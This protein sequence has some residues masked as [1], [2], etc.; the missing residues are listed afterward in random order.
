MYLPQTTSDRINKLLATTN[1]VKADLNRYCGINKGTIN[2]S[3]KSKYGLGAKI[4]Y[5]IADFLS[6]SVDY[7]LGRTDS[8]TG[9]AESLT[10]T[11]YKL[12]AA[13]RSLPDIDKARVLERAE[14]LA[15][16]HERAKKQEA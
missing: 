12:I 9:N 6:C 5:D 15:D 14:T 8:A 3:V 10:P 2:E 16:D 1:N 13:F 4:L 7:L 11:E